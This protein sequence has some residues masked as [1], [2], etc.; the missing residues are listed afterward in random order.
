MK[1]L[2]SDAFLESF[3]AAS[4]LLGEADAVRAA[5]R[6]VALAAALARAPSRPARAALL[7]EAVARAARELQQARIA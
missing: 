3:V 7:A 6:D 4:A 5:E 1:M 2:G